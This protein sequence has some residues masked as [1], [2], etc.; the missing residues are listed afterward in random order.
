MHPSHQPVPPLGQ[1]MYWGPS[2]CRP[3]QVAPLPPPGAFRGAFHHPGPQAPPPQRPP[4]LAQVQAAALLCTSRLSGQGR[5]ASFGTVV[6]MVLADYGAVDWPQLGLGQS[7]LVVPCL[8]YLWTLE[9]QVSTLVTAFSGLRGIASLWDLE[10]EVLQLLNSFCIPTLQEAFPAPGS[11]PPGPRPGRCPPSPPATLPNPEEIQLS[12]EEDDEEYED[13]QGVEGGDKAREPAVL[14]AGSQGMETEDDLD[15]GEHPPALSCPSQSFVDYGVGPLTELPA[16]LHYFQPSAALRQQGPFAAMPAADVFPHLLEFLQRRGEEEWQ[17]GGSTGVWQ[18]AGEASAGG[19]GDEQSNKRHR[20]PPSGQPT[21]HGRSLEA[22]AAMALE[23]STYLVQQLGVQDLREVGIRVAPLGLAVEVQTL[24]H[25]AAAQRAAV[26]KEKQRALREIQRANAEAEAASS[27][28]QRQARAAVQQERPTMPPTGGALPAVPGLREPPRKPVAG[29]LA[30]CKEAVDGPWRPTFSKMRVV[31]EGSFK[32]PE[33]STEVLLDVATEYAML[34]LGGSKF[35]AKRIEW[36]VADTDQEKEEE[37]EEGPDDHGGKTSGSSSGDSTSAST[38][39]SEDT[40]GSSE[41]SSSGE[42]G[43]GGEEKRS[44]PAGNGGSIAQGQ[45]DGQHLEKE[46][47]HMKPSA[48]AG[49]LLPVEAGGRAGKP[50]PS[51]MVTVM[52]GIPPAGGRAVPW[53]GAIRRAQQPG[54]APATDH[55]ADEAVLQACIPWHQSL[56]PNNSRAVGR[57]GEALVY[58]YL[59]SHCPGATVKWMNAEGES[60]AAYDIEVTSSSGAMH[61]TR[62]VEVKTSVHSD[63]NA[64]EMSLWE[65]EFAVKAGKQYSIFRVASAGQPGRT[66]IRVFNNPYSAVQEHRLGLC[67]LY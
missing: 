7:P 47:E 27:A 35:R 9:Q 38:S 55:L 22:S 31:V 58:Q 4:T 19:Y 36:K 2:T 30:R 44:Q 61:E 32:L 48:V 28:L 5:F 24:R 57:W 25:V 3:P 54:A 14:P 62:F 12:E 1:A 43:S 40:E 26:V 67:L 63:K 11:E 64:F 16:V 53:E 52:E 66:H 17:Q 15:P 20:G 23:F 39:S 46:G 18:R 59:L 50:G 45:T 42:S 21:A 56:D 8:S 33:G 34:H 37:E 10:S 49:S 29:F 60:R 6:G 13:N 65:W 51:T 41:D